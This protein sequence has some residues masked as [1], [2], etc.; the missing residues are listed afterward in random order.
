MS[1]RGIA[2]SRDTTNQGVRGR[3][4]SVR[5]LSAALRVWPLA[6]V[7]SRPPGKCPISSVQVMSGLELSSLTSMTPP[8][9][10]NWGRRA[11]ALWNVRICRCAGM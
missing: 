11:D 7:G 10:N 6:M 1:R 9:D 8:T 4:S 5:V 2:C 3:M